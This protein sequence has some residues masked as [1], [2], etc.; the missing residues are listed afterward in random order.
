M[1][2]RESDIKDFVISFDKPNDLKTGF[3]FT[4]NS[5]TDIINVILD[6][7]SDKSAS[8]NAVRNVTNR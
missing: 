4:N 5:M 7:P 1:S 3:R 8:G 6:L 2:G